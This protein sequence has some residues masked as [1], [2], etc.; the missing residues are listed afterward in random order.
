MSP[1]TAVQ[2]QVLAAVRACEEKKA[3]DLAI[4]RLAPGSGA[5]TDY[6]VLC[7]GSNPRQIQTIADAVEERLAGAHLHPAHHEG[8]HQAEW[9]LLDYIDFVVHIFSQRARKYYDL[10]R[11]WRSAARLAPDEV[12]LPVK[13]HEP[14][15]GPG[16]AAKPAARSAKKH[17]LRGPRKPAASRKRSTKKR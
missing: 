14:V 5:F 13:K 2:Y 3:E 9:I 15:A 10:E 1:P 8:Y 17:S 6:F 16:K 4:L 7:N 12:L 11:L